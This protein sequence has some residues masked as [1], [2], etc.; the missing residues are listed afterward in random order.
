MSH[1]ANKVTLWNFLI[2]TL[3]NKD[4]CTI[5]ALGNGL[6]VSLSTQTELKNQ[7]DNFDWFQGVII[8]QGVLFY[9][10]YTGQTDTA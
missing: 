5:W 4:I 2:S 9:F 7:E 6:K 3:E 1:A 8:I 10:Y